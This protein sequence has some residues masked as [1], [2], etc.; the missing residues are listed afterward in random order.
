MVPAA[1]D[2]AQ[3]LQKRHKTAA[4]LQSPHSYPM[5]APGLAPDPRDA[6]MK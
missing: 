5:V 1:R 6:R 4:L 2:V 3:S